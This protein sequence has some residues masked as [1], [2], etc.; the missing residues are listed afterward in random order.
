MADA[1][2]AT[3]CASAIVLTHPLFASRAP[4]VNERRRGTKPGTISLAMA[5]RRKIWVQQQEQ[6]QRE[7]VRQEVI[8]RTRAFFS[9]KPEDRPIFLMGAI[10]GLAVRIEQLEKLAGGRNVDGAH[11]E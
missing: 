4:V 5:R 9:A 6:E 1:I 8:S 2:T 11:H 3:D 7:Q 10:E